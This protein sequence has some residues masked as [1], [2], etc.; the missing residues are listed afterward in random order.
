MPA[1]ENWRGFVAGDATLAQDVNGQKQFEMCY[2]DADTILYQAAAQLQENYILVTSKSSGKS[3]RFKGVREFYGLK[4]SR[5]GGW[6]G[7]RNA[8]RLEKGMPPLTLDMFEI[9]QKAEIIPAPNVG[10]TLVEYGLQLVGFKIGEIKKHMQSEDYRA[11]IGGGRNFR[12]D[13]AKITPYK[14]TRSDKPLLLAELR[15][16]F[17][18][19]YS[20]RAILVDSSIETDDYVS[21]KGWESYKGYLKTGKWS[22][23]IAYV[24]KDL[25]QVP[26][27]YLNYM[28]ISEGIV[29]PDML[30]CAK[31]FAI[32]L[33]SGDK[34]DTVQGLPN[35]SQEFA[36]KYNITQR[37][38]GVS[39]AEKILDG[40]K[41]PKDLYSR[42]VEAYKSYYGD[43]DFSFTSYDGEVSQRCWM[44]MLKENAALL[45]MLRDM[46]EIGKYDIMNTLE[47]LGV[48]YK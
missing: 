4:K 8:I 22:N 40:A 41:T 17:L 20:K 31:S 9:E 18:D 47:R 43:S 25:R 44:D 35:T 42:V 32:Q 28:K 19:T 15:E 37:G 7:E 30:D 2:I 26:C 23:I 46:G 27:P 21:I 38:I 10:Q 1:V 34:S 24:D 16:A 5:D 39:T 33:L 6:I 48:E 29:F 11:C 45:Y 36:K 12:Y 3:K 14:N 13:I